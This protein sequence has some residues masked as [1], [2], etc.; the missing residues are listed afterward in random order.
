MSAKD[1]EK[2]DKEERGLEEVVKCEDIQTLFGV[3]ESSSNC[4]YL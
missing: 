2:E 1:S 4:N 3:F